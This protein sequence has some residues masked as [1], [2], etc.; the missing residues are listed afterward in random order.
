VTLG[1]VSK[2]TDPPATSTRPGD[3]RCPAA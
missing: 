2:R 3:R 1:R